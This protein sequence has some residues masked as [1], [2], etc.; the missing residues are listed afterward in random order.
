MQFY[1]NSFQIF[2]ST[3]KREL[4]DTTIPRTI[5]QFLFYSYYF[6]ILCDEDKTD[7]RIF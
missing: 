7:K 5:L 6:G 4:Q 3:H 2:G 1:V